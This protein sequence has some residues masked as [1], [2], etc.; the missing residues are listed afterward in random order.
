MWSGYLKDEKQKSFLE[1]LERNEIPLDEC[2]TS[3]HAA[4]EDLVKLRKVFPH[5]PLVPI[6]TE[7]PD[8]YEEVFGNVQQKNDGEWWEVVP[9]ERFKIKER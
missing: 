1:W 8:R 7:Y 3:G 9:G 2:H 5:V 4:V 6:H